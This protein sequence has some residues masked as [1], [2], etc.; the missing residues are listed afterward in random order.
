MML[1]TQETLDGE[2]IVDSFAGGGGASTGIELALGRIVNAAIN[3][4]PAAI[5]M[6]EANHPHTEHYQ[7]SVWD[8]DP[9]TVC[10]GRPV[11]L[12][13]FSPDC[14]HFSKAKGAALVDRKIRG[15][16]WIVLRWAAKV[17]PRVIILE[18]VEEFQTW[19]PVR[20]GKPV[21]ELA[22]TTFQKFVG[23][24]RALGYTVEWRE[25]VAADYGAPTTRRRLV[26]IARCDGRAIVW[27]ERTHAPRGSAEVRSGKLLPWRSAAEIIDWSLPCPSIFATKDE[28]RE[29]YGISAVRPLADNTVRRIIRGVDKFT[30]KSGAPFIVECSH[31]GDVHVA[32]LTM[33]NTS[34][35]AGAPVSE[36]MNTVRTGGG[37]GQML[38][39]PSLIQYHT[40]K[41]ES[42]RAAGLDKPIC[43]VDASNRYGLTCANLVEYYSAGRPLDAQEPMHTVTSHDREAVVA[44]HVVKYKRDEVGTRPSEPLPTQTAGGVFGCCKAVLCKIGTSERLY[45]WPQIRDL[46]NRYCGYALGTDD[47][48]LLSIGGVLYYI[49]DI[50]L[51]MLSP[52]ELYNAMG[53]PPDYII[54]HD[55]GGK[56]YP[57]TQQVARCGNAVCP[58]MAA[59]VVAANLPEYAVP[60]KI[61]TMA[62]LADAVAM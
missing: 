5:R 8:V 38:L 50:G 56:P 15:L 41:T 53:F 7:A 55:A 1:R 54:D 21:K 12:A 52:R 13:W 60:G 40:E 58:P 37:G 18:N 14:K 36:P 62:A 11:A 19:G 24:L 42:A 43:T 45:Y 29:R 6:H 10:R 33:T 59:A 47:L 16:A 49:A 23:Q 44:A 32:P 17:R 22:G 9:E 26:L 46:L 4:D 57:K 30:I 25:L 61:E 48:L 31:S 34:N 27:P 39:S 35:S 3:H 28:S 20:K 2:I 51:R